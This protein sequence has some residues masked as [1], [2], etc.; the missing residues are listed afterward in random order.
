[1][2]VVDS[3]SSK[4]FNKILDFT[5]EIVSTTMIVTGARYFCFVVTLV[6]V[7]VTAMIV[8]VA[9]NVLLV[10]ILTMGI[11][12]LV[13]AIVMPV[14]LIR[15][16]ANLVVVLLHHFVAEF[17]FGVK[18]DLFLTLLC[19]QAI[20]HLRVE[21]ILEVLGNGLEFFVAEALFALEVPCTVLLVKRHVKP[22]NFE[23]VVGRGHVPRRKG[24]G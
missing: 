9:T 10:V 1:M 24:F 18:L 21:D 3:E 17:R 13:A 8:V 4:T 11:A 23:C 7:I 14:A 22:L 16:V 12:T 15:E 6:V 5:E 2:V 20:G 19:E